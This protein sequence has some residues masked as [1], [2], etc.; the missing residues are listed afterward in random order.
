MNKNK[1]ID[2]SNKVTNENKKIR[3]LKLV[4]III[5]II[6]VLITFFVS[7]INQKKSEY[8]ANEDY[9]ALEVTENSEKLEEFAGN[10]VIDNKN[11]NTFDFTDSEYLE[12]QKTNESISYYY[13]ELID[14]PFYLNNY[15]RRMLKEAAINLNTAYINFKSVS[16]NYEETIE[17]NSFDLY[18][19]S[20]NES[21]AALLKAYDDYNL[22]AKTRYSIDY[23]FSW[24]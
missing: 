24:A 6:F 9:F 12:L 19:S 5:I 23:V 1:Q 14:I 13:E 17:N 21:S 10:F 8:S 7:Y 15:D 11:G 16:L 4:A 2:D 22:L 18:R 20:V 3:I